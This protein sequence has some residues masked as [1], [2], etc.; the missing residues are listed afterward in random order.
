M[1]SHRRFIRITLILVIASLLMLTTSVSRI[2]AAEG[3]IY[4]DAFPLQTYDSRFYLVFLEDTD[5]IELNLTNTYN[6]DFDIF[7]HEERPL[8]YYVSHSGYDSKIYDNAVAYNTS[9]GDSASL[10]YTV[11]ESKIYYIQVVMIDNGPDTYRLNSTKPL[12]LYFIPYLIPGFH[13]DVVVGVSFLAIFLIGLIYYKKRE[14]H[15]S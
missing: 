1:R 12:E 2:K 10:S 15:V 5:T 14:F 8:D 3:D 7:L 11:S 13:T 6:G 4:K 9:S